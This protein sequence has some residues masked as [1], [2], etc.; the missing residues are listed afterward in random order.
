MSQPTLIGLHSTKPRSG[1]STVAGYLCRE[2]GYQVRPFAGPL[3]RMVRQFLEDAGFSDGDILH[4]MSD[5][6]E[7]L[8]PGDWPRPTTA[9]YLMQT[10]GTEWGREQ[11]GYG[12]WLNL[13][14]SSLGT[15]KIVVDDVRFLNEAEE[16]KARGGEVWL[17]ERGIQSSADVLKHRS[18]SGL[19]DDYQFDAVLYNR[20][21]IRDLEKIV[22]WCL[23]RPE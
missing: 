9:R 21:A 23:E 1:K 20:A 16:I 17:V 8:L 14:G 19:G 5:G 22:K 11:I 7:E 3:K 4:Y 15:G 10:L 12:I 13:W 2:F 6:K 18:E